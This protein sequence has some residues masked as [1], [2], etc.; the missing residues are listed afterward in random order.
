MEVERTRAIVKNMEEML[1]EL[2][3]DPRVTVNAYVL[4]PPQY[5]KGRKSALEAKR[6]ELAQQGIGTL[7]TTEFHREVLNTLAFNA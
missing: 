7:Q 1:S 3:L 5:S 6:K 2:H 4:F